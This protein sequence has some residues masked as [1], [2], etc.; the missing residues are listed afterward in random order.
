M[1]LHNRGKVVAIRLVVIFIVTFTAAFF[2]LNIRFVEKNV[3]YL[4]APGTIKTR[5][6][7]TDAI[8]LL[9]LAQ[10]VQA[11]PLPD[12]ATLVIDSIGVR[13]PI[14]F[15]V[16]DNNDLIYKSLEGGV[17]HYSNT[18]KPGNPGA[19]V[20]L[21]HSSAFP[22]YKGDYGAVFAL[23]SKLKIGDRF[24]VQ[25]SDNRTFVYE[26]TQSIIFNPFANDE[27]LTALENAQG[28]T[29]ILISCYPVGTNYKRIA[30]Q[31]KQV[32]M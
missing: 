15:N 4:I 26:M 9:P 24:Y 13:A 25:Y 18:A 22:W 5:D 30:V 1:R 19:A 6:T 3:Q 23:L 32:Q 8:R 10:N 21:G 7:L 27:R 29:L 28:S 2:L 20:I 16:A 11:K 17:V 14:V 12:Q 31:A